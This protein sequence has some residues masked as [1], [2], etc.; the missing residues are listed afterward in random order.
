MFTLPKLPYPYDALEPFY[1][2][3]TVE[4]HHSKHHQTYTD[5]FNAALAAA[6]VESSDAEEIL[7]RLNEIS[8]EKRGAVRNHGGGY[9][10][11]AF[12][13]ESLAPNLT[14]ADT[15]PSGELLSSLEAKFGSFEAFQK[16][17][18]E[19]ALNHFGSGWAWLVVNQN[20][21]LE[22][23]DTHDQVCPLTFGQKP[24]LTVD[25][26]EHAY[27][28]KYQN[29]R[30]EWISNFWKVVNWKEVEKRFSVNKA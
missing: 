28:L 4:I 10:N 7:M 9:W 14:G 6:G 13:W 20:G 21:E 2:K 18:T 11:H 24:L 22:I 30:P 26:W 3:E 23:T 8:E 5:K 25:V 1:D 17:F 19:K 16:L 15:K 12:F 29:R 27:Y